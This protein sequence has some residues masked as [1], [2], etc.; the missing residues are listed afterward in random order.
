MNEPTL[1]R[2][3]GVWL[4]CRVSAGRGDLGAEGLTLLRSGFRYG[5][6]TPERVL[7]RNRKFLFGNLLKAG[8]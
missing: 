6:N 8:G 1:E 3:R 7:W 2:P 4:A 5:H